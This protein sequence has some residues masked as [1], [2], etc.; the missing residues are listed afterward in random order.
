[1]EIGVLRSRPVSKHRLQEPVP[2]Q[3]IVERRVLPL[4]LR[5]SL[6]QTPYILCRALEPSFRH[7]VLPTHILDLA[8]RKSFHGDR[9]LDVDLNAGP[10][11]FDPDLA[12]FA[13]KGPDQRKGVFELRATPK[14]EGDWGVV[15]GGQQAFDVDP[16]GDVGFYG[17]QGVLR[18][19]GEDFYGGPYVG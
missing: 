18:G 8:R 3:R 11:G 9:G 5:K 1:M 10:L 15:V 6:V 13:L 2:F 4:P 17:A 19:G 16:V 12:F 7:P 14:K